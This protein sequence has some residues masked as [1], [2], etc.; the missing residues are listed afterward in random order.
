[1][2]EADLHDYESGYATRAHRKGAVTS[3]GSHGTDGEDEDRDRATREGNPYETAN[4]L[5]KSS[6]IDGLP[7][8]S[9]WSLF[10]Q[11]TF[12]YEY[13]P[14]AVAIDESKKSVEL[15]KSALC[16]KNLAHRPRCR[17]RCE[18]ERLF[19][20]HELTGERIS[21]AKHE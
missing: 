17:V 21:E 5:Q 12:I 9:D 8:I 16:N 19:A 2:L 11:Q 4:D 14:V 20:H 15:C 7:T 18:P 10:R 13:R 3:L 1:V 6:N